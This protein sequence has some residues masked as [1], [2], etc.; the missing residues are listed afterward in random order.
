MPAIERPS[1]AI[2]SRNIERW[3]FRIEGSS[4]AEL[5]YVGQALSLIHG[6][7]FGL[8]CVALVAACVWMS[9]IL[10]PL[11]EDTPVAVGTSFCSI[12]LMWAVGG[13]AAQR[14]AGR[15]VEAIKEW[16]IGG[17][18]TMFVLNLTTILR[19]NVFLDSVSQ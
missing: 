1:P 13:Y 6:V 3:W 4:G 11:A 12:L 5:W 10:S 16:A 9:T 15:L 8:V 19:N 14:R 2:S 18:V 7:R 17:V